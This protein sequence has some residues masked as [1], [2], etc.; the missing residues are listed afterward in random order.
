MFPRF[1]RTKNQVKSNKPESSPFIYYP[2]RIRFATRKQ[3]VAWLLWHQ[4][5]RHVSQKKGGMREVG[6]SVLD[7]NVLKDILGPVI[8]EANKCLVHP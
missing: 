3:C 8:I 2:Q 6:M 1:K 4:Q 5:M 7:V